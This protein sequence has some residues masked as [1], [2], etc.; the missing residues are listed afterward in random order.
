MPCSFVLDHNSIVQVILY[1][2]HVR[3]RVVQSTQ[4]T[5]CSRVRNQYEAQTWLFLEL[6]YPY[7]LTRVDTTCFIDA[8]C[9]TV[10][11]RKLSGDE[12]RAVIA[13]YGST[14]CRDVY[15]WKRLRAEAG[16][17]VVDF[18][19]ISVAGATRRRRSGLQQRTPLPSPRTCDVVYNE[20]ARANLSTEE[21][22]KRGKHGS[23]SV[24]DV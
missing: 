11:I 19:G 1:P 4:H 9:I 5:I 10:H 17:R 21:V 16:S 23:H 18:G 8:V 3:G 15:A 13:I 2:A 20:C 6:S 14:P 22:L 7:T 12:A 24:R